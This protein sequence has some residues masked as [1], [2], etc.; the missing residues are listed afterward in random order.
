VGL[1]L[2]VFV[3]SYPLARLPG[4]AAGLA[5]F[6]VPGPVKACAVGHLYGA[7]GR[8]AAFGRAILRLGLRLVFATDGA[9]S[10]GFIRLRR[11]RPDL[12]SAEMWRRAGPIRWR[13]FARGFWVNVNQLATQLSAGSDI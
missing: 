11:L 4:R 3:I 7:G 12:L 5:G 8:D 2:A 13:W 6:E 9:R 1:I 10:G